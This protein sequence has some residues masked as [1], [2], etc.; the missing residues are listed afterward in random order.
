VF[1]AGV[2]VTEPEVCEVVVIV[3]PLSVVIETVVAFEAC[4]LIVTLWPELIEPGLTVNFVTSGAAADT[5]TFAVAGVLE[6]PGPVAVAVYVVVSVG[7]SLTVPDPCELVV[8]VRVAVPLV[9]VIVTESAFEDCQ[10]RVTLWPDVMDFELADNDTVG[11]D[12]AALDAPEHEDK[13]HVARSTI[14]Q[15]T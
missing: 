4:Q 10:L 8:T 5:S 7:E 11:V 3:L 13:A 14:P 1:D 9:A 15:K 2:S 6:P 12:E